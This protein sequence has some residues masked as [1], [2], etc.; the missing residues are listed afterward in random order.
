MDY[1]R[2]IQALG[3]VHFNIID[4]LTNSNARHLIILEHIN[5][6]KY[7]R[8]KKYITANNIKKVPFEYL[9][10][11]IKFYNKPLFDSYY[12]GSIINKIKLNE[13]IH[14]ILNEAISYCCSGITCCFIKICICNNHCYFN[15]EKNFLNLQN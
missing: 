14:F 6:T 3:I 12:I 7:Y 5:S 9:G 2:M 13:T 8:K 1:E 15:D 4:F 10:K 11:L